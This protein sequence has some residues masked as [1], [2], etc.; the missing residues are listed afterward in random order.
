MMDVTLK[1][2]QKAVEIGGWHDGQCTG[3]EACRASSMA[4]EVWAMLHAHAWDSP[5][6]GYVAGIDYLDIPP[7]PEALARQKAFMEQKEK[8]LKARREAAK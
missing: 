2:I 1:D 6:E 8:D 7:A 4:I 3:L 5:D